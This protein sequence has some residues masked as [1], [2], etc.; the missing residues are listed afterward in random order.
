MQQIALQNANRRNSKQF[1]T[2]NN[3]K[4]AMGSQEGYDQ[5]TDGFSRLNNNQSKSPVNR[6]F[7]TMHGIMNS[8]D[9]N[10]EELDY[11]E[12]IEEEICDNGESPLINAQSKQ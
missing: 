10:E 7:S 6:Q 3:L 8:Q 9:R 5:Q 2:S 12:L 4:K 11:E 1:S